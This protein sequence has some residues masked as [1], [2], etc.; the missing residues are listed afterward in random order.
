[1]RKSN[2]PGGLLLMFILI[3]ACRS[4]SMYKNV[5]DIPKG[6]WT[7]TQNIGFDVPV[8]DTINGYNLYFEI[9]NTN[10]YPYSNLFLF[11]TTHSPNK[12][13]K[14]DTLEITLAD[15]KGKWLGKGLGGVRNNEFMFKNNIRFP[16]AGFYKVEVNQGMRD[17]VLKGIM[18]IGLKVERVR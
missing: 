8:V 15:D 7:K 6:A 10:D 5:I 14:K 13:I 18:D 16:V 9:R 2:L 4:N 1:M 17:D 12:A 3:V 11:V